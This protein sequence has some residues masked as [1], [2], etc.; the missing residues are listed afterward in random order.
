MDWVSDW[1]PRVAEAGACWEI[2]LARAGDLLGSACTESDGGPSNR[3]KQDEA[4]SAHCLA[5]RHTPQLPQPIRQPLQR[6][7]V[8][9]P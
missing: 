8:V 4:A 9:L 6:L 5:A 2:R 1:G 3:H 7:I